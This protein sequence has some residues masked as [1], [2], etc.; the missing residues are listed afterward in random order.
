MAYWLLKSEPDEYSFADLE[1]DRTTVWNGVRNHQAINYIRTMQPG[2]LALIYHTGKERQIVGTAT[3]TTAAYPD[4]AAP[5][6]A[7]APPVV[8]VQVGQR[9]ATPITLAT[10]KADPFFADFALVRQGRLSVVPVSE[11][12]WAYLT[13]LA[14][15]A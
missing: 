7:T 1:R 6:P 3:I 2:D 12:Q 9:L 15:S 4:P 5:D 13:T 11:A 8:D 10:I 14:E